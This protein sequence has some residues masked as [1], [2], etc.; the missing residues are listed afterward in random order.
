MESVQLG[1][2]LG[3]GEELEVD[4]VQHIAEG[5]PPW[6]VRP[7]PATVTFVPAPLELP[8]SSKG[9]VM[10]SAQRTGCGTGS[11]RERDVSQMWAR[12]RLGAGVHER[13]AAVRR[14][15]VKLRAD[16]GYTS[17]GAT[18]GFGA[19]AIG[20]AARCRSLASRCQLIVLELIVDIQGL[21]ALVPVPPPNAVAVDA[22]LHV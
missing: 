2:A 21:G 11:S 4:G 10:E 17:E 1:C 15:G 14:T 19:P 18:K 5:E 13:S 12:C 3:V 7:Q 16:G 20:G 6:E 9:M 22:H 8:S